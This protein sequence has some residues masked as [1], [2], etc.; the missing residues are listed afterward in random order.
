MARGVPF[1]SAFRLVTGTTP[2]EFEQQFRERVTPK[3]PFL[4]YILLQNLE[5]SLLALGGVVIAIGYVRWR[6][7]RERAMASLDLTPDD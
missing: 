2:A 4:L 1:E 5:V 7:R 6:L 3:I